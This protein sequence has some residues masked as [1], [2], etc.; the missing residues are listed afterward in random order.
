M[1]QNLSQNI[2]KIFNKIKGTGI[3]TESN[4][5]SALRDIRIALLEADVSLPVVKEFISLVKERSL[6]QEVISS[7]SPGQMIIKIMHDEM[8]R[9]LEPKDDEAKINLSASAPVNI[10]IAGLQGS[11]KTTA[12]AKIALH[13]KKQNKKLLLVSL[14]TYRPAAQQQLEILA[15]SISVD[16]LEII[17]GQTPI[18]ITHRALT[19]SKLSGYDVVIYDTAGRLHIDEEMIKE[20]SLVKDLVK[21][22]ETLLIVDSMIGQDAMNVISQ[23]NE[24]LGITGTILS[25]IDGDAK[26]GVALSIRHITGAP[27]KFL[28]TGEKIQDFEAFD[29]KRIVDRIL[30]MGDVV[31]FVEKAAELIDQK[32]AEKSLAKLQKGKFDMNDY[33]KQLNMLKKMGGISSVM[34]MLPGMGAMS[35]KIAQSGINEKLFLQ[36]ES[37]ICSM[38]KKEKRY[39]ELLNASRKKRIASGSG[40]TVQQVNSMLKQ[41]EKISSVMKKMSKMNPASLMRGM[42]DLGFGG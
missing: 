12:S 36:Q 1:F 15:N 26:G 3:I 25:R 2:T 11:G 39:P 8:V 20:V 5:E 34:K 13:L 22:T 7:V 29:A 19:M 10:L 38:T 40:T 41:Y 6:G 42:K 16:C 33:V 21:P 27:I 4:I 30:D 9:L 28:S 24:K 23:F 31:S 17:Q 18:E 35:E 37:I 32:E 14:D